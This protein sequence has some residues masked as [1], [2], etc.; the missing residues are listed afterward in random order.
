MR[1]EVGSIDLVNGTPIF[2]IK[3]YIAY[4]DSQPD[5]VCGF[6]PSKPATEIEVRF[7]A[8]ALQVIAQQQVNYPNLQR[9]IR[10]LI[11]QD[12]RPAYQQHQSGQRVYG[13]SIWQFN[14]CF[15]FPEVG[16]AEVLTTE[17]IS[18]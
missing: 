11:Q 16:I 2:D 12:P 8:P 5:A 4:A 1:L 6:A 15:C 3:P 13:M 18:R 10:E 7:Q 14:I 17:V 9:F